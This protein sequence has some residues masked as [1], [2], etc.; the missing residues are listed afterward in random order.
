M[1]PY[2]TGTP[3]LVLTS[4]HQ[5][6]SK[7][8]RTRF[9]EIFCAVLEARKESLPD[10]RPCEDALTR[11]SD[12][13]AAS[14]KPVDLGASKRHLVVGFVPGLGW[15]CF[16]DWL[17]VTGSVSAHLAQFGYDAKLVPV[18]GLA[19]T[20]ENARRIR[21]AI[22]AMP[23]NDG[24]RPLVL[25]GYSKGLPDL[26][27]AIVT[28]PEIRQHLA[29]VVSAAGA[30]GGSPLANRSHESD[31]DL[32]V[33]VP[34]AK[35]E[36]GDGHAVESL[37]TS[38]RQTWLAQHPL[39]QDVAYYSL[40]TFPNPDHISRVLRGS[41]DKL[42]KID[43]RNDSQL[44]FYDEVIPG[45]TLVG[46]VNADHWAL[47]VPVSRTHPSISAM[48]VTRNAYPREALFEAL[49]RLVEEDLET[50]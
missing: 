30:V 39:P 12:E 22:L 9:R 33:H 17:N 8:E 27:E 29:A 44:I 4:A 43:A 3:P 16:A 34:G 18:G 47:A 31:A 5:A 10:Y 49:L 46:Y 35:C 7:D 19:G 37:R 38:V 20:E 36:K 13:P 28:Y 21:D 23:F 14:G 45:S 24:E 25:V 40:V 50:R 1:V 41:Y 48:F 42:S 2:G 11:I 6:G 15:E 32:L 26:L